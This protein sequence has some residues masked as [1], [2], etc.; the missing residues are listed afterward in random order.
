MYRGW[1]QRRHMQVT[2]IAGAGDRRLPWLLISGFGAHRTLIPETGLHVFEEDDGEGTERFTARVRVVAAPLGDL[3]QDRLKA[4]LKASFAALAVPQS[5]VRR[6]RAEPAPLVRQI[7]GTTWRSG[8][9]E[10][11]MG[12]DFDLIGLVHTAEA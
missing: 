5:V 7:A 10:A 12:G 8:K 3:S 9:L 11:V 4:Q 6:Y 2:E 1:A